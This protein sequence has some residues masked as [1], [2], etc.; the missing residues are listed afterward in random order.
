V[1]TDRAIDQGEGM[2]SRTVHIGGAE[3]SSL[4][5]CDESCNTSI[6]MFLISFILS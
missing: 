5:P 4:I 3:R 6:V 1:H 2:D